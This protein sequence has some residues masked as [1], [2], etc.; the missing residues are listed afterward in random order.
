MPFAYAS[1]WSVQAF[2]SRPWDQVVDE[3][4]SH[5]GELPREA[6]IEWAKLLGASRR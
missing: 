6:Q 1:S 3:V 2:I 4:S 5:I